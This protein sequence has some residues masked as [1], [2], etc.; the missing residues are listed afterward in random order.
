MRNANL[1]LSRNPNTV[2]SLTAKAM[3]F[4]DNLKNE[5]LMN[6][7]HTRQYTLNSPSLTSQGDKL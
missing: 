5:E 2:H 6:C 3:S 1:P 4:G 7:D